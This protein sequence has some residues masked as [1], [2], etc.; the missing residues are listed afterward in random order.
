MNMF[1]LAIFL[2]P[3]ST[4]E[5]IKNVALELIIRDV[6]TFH[7]SA[8]NDYIIVFGYQNKAWEDQFAKIA[9]I[10]STF[11]RIHDENDKPN[12]QELV[13]ELSSQTK[14]NEPQKIQEP[15][16]LRRSKSVTDAL[17]EI[18]LYTNHINREITKGKTKSFSL[19]VM[20]KNTVNVRK[21]GRADLHNQKY[22]DPV[23]PDL[24]KKHFSEYANAHDV[25]N[26]ASPFFANRAHPRR[27][28]NTY[29]VYLHTKAWDT[30]QN[31]VT[32]KLDDYASAATTRN[33]IE[34]WSLEGALQGILDIY[35]NVSD[36]N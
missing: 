3:N 34:S 2:K 32:G 15:Y 16:I 12:S 33:Y 13:K 7:M 17:P 28:L 1:D 24:W 21:A 18:K 25:M 10:S 27:V 5:D 22:P 29:I 6:R 20:S 19:D 23:T 14:E 35:E 30:T 26:S 4:K 31:F 8:N 11:M 9:G 36:N